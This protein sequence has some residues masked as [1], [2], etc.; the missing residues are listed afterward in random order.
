MTLTQIETAVAAWLNAIRGARQLV[1]GRIGEAPVPAV[2]YLTYSVDLVD[3]PDLVPVDLGTTT[4]TARASAT[5]IELVVQ[6][7]GDLPDGHVARNDAAA[8]VLSLRHSQRWAD[9]Y[10]AA[11][12]AGVSPIRNLSQLETGAMRQRF[13]VRLTLSAILTA[14]APAELI[15]TVQAGIYES[16]IPTVIT[17]EI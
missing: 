13:D 2:P 6:F 5:P 8:A 3:V 1:K 15:E 7:V 17:L 16:T 4:Q 9:L 14:D 10:T 11:G 12:L